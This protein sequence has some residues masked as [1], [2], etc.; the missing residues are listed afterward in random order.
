MDDSLYFSTPPCA[1]HGLRSRIASALIALLALVSAQQAAAQTYTFATLHTFAVSDGTNPIDGVFQ[2]SDGTLFG[3]TYGT[4]NTSSPSNDGGS[5]YSM[6]TDGTSFTVLHAFSVTNSGGAFN[7]NGA[8]PEYNPVLA[9]DGKLYGVT[10]QGGQGAYGVLYQLGTDGSG[11]TLYKQF[12][13]PTP[14]T[15]AEYQTNGLAIGSDGFLYGAGDSAGNADSSDGGAIDEWQIYKL[16]ITNTGYVDP[17]KQFHETDG[18][19]GFNTLLS[20]SDGNLYGVTDGDEDNSTPASAPVIFKLTT[21]GTYTQLHILPS[22][23]EPLA[24][25]IQGSGTALYGSTSEGGTSAWG[26]VFTINTDGTGFTTLHS[27]NGTTDGAY[28]LGRLLLASDGKLYG[29][30]Y[31]GGTSASGTAGN[32]YG[33]I[34][35]I[36][37]DGTGFTVIYNFTGATGAGGDHAYPNGALIQGSDG[38]FYGTTNDQDFNYDPA[39]GTGTIFSLA[40][41]SPSVTSPLTAS[42]SYGAPF[43]YTISG[44]NLPTSYSVTGTL[45]AGV[46]LTS[47]SGLISGTPTNNGS[48]SVTIGA[49]NGGGTGTAT[50]LITIAKATLTYH[51]NAASSVYGAATSSLGGTVTGFVNSDNQSTATTGTLSFTTT[52][53]P[54]SN[55]GTYAIDGTGLTANGGNYVFVQAAANSTAYTVGAAMLTYAANS[56]SSAHGASLAALGG[57]VTG[58]VNGDNQTSATTGTLSFSTT[59]TATSVVGNYAITGSGLTSDHGNYTFAQASGNSSAY[60]VTTATLTVSGITANGR[61]YNSS[62]AATINLTGAA[63]VGVM[64]GDT[65]TLGTGGATGSFL[66]KTVGTLKTVAISGLTLG[67]SNS[68]E[69]TLTQPM[70]MASISSAGLT[71]SGVTAS[72]K[73]YDSTQTAT[74]NT[75]SAALVGVFSGDTVTLGT[76]GATGL[77]ATKTVGTGK[78]VN[79]AGLTIGGADSGNYSLTQPTATASISS[80]SLNVSGATA[81]NKAYD[82]TLSATINTGGASLVGVFSGDTV[83][84][85]ASGATGTFATKTVGAG[86]TVTIAGLTLGGADSGNYSL[87]QPAA[88]ASISSAGLTVSGVTASGKV[89]DSTRTATIGTGSAA[90][91]GVFS[92]DTVTLGT[93]AATGL[94]ATKTVGVGKTVAIT[95]LTI[96]GADSGNY[97][98][99]QPTTTATISSADLTVSGVTASNK[100]Y[101]GSTL[102]TIGTSGAALVG[103]LGGDSVTLVTSGASGAFTDANAGANKTVTVAGLTI[104]G[105]DSGNYILTEPT[106][107]ATITAAAITPTLGSLGQTYDGTVKN[108]SIT[109]VP[110][111]LTALY[112]YNGVPQAVTLSGGTLSSYAAAIGQDIY[113]SVTGST[114]GTVYGTTTYGINSDVATAA[115]HD[116]VL[117]SGQQAV[118]EVSVLADQGSY[119]GSTQNGVSS[120]SEGAAGGS[121][122]IV[123]IATSGY[124]MGPVG[125]GTYSVVATIVDPNYTGSVSGTLVIG[126]ATPVVT[127]ATPLPIVYGVPLSGTQLDA[128]ANVAGTFAYTP[129]AGNLVPAGNP[130]LSVLFTPTDGTDYTTATGAVTLS[131]STA[132]AGVTLGSLSQTYS[133]A[134]EPATATTTPSSLT[135]NFTYNG[136]S[137]VPMT[138]GTYAVV[139]TISDPD[140]TGTAS[141][142]LV[143]GQATPVI[144]WPQPANVPAGTALSGTQLN[145]TANVPGVFT[146]NPPSGA[147]VASGGVTLGVLFTPSDTLDYTTATASVLL[148]TQALSQ[149]LSYVQPIN[150][151]TNA[152]PLTLQAMASSGLPVTFTVL[153]GPAM[154]NGST[155][156]VTG[157]PGLVT[158]QV[159][160]PGSDFYNP[161][162]SQTFTLSVQAVGPRMFFASTGGS[163]SSSTARGGQT[164]TAGPDTNVAAYVAPDDST[165]T[166]VAY[167]PSLSEGMVVTFT[168]DQN[169]NFSATTTALTG[170]STPGPTLTLTGQLA[171]NTLSGTISQLGISFTASLDPYDG[172][173]A[174]ISGYYPSPLINSSTGTVYSV[175]GTQ[176][177]VYVLTVGPGYV[178]GSL[179]TVGANDSYTAQTSTTTS[180]T[181]TIDPSTTTVTG[182]EILPSGATAQFGG[183]SGSTLRTDRLINLSSR[184]MV[185]GGQNILI[186]GFVIAGP[187]PKAVLLRAVGPG[188]D[189]FGVPGTLSTPKLTLEDSGG[190]LIASNSAWGGGASLASVF[191]RVGAFA[192]PAASADCA[193]LTTL[194]P[195]AYTM[196]V[197]SADAGAGG[198]ALAEIYDASVNPQSEYQRLVNISTRG[199]VTSGAGVLIGGFIVTGNSPKTLLI[200]GVGPGLSPFGVSGALSDPVLTVFDSA[201]NVLAQNDDWGTPVT[202]IPAQTAASPANIAAAEA[203]AG[204]FPFASGSKD[205][206]VIVTLQPGSYTAQV[207]GVGGATGTALIEVYEVTQ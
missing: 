203:L 125:A 198:I 178:Y 45:P 10:E 33:T 127:W 135:V 181:G 113:V 147:A 116:G 204:A 179:G 3:S 96:G 182:T 1:L 153:S 97:S 115:V 100:V 114:A 8:N 26:S 86:K 57:T 200:R 151:L 163:T 85:V 13:Y 199:Q 84:L 128:T 149:T 69:Y 167:F 32:G 55:T 129:A 190:N 39:I 28:P 111:G 80:A 162:P 176:D 5:V 160:Q 74:I 131:V 102:A 159:S 72:G 164:R 65:V 64:P 11:F 41:T 126:Q 58:F 15:L 18:G 98:L 40:G 150:L 194:A 88:T 137:T 109:T 107:T 144:T 184:G 120:L 7:T 92:G 185:S 117:T 168:P 68:S 49:I 189:N 174:G 143:I 37:T 79:I 43:S 54:S 29:T 42:G 17:F 119:T 20:A 158:I 31:Q 93:G 161:A 36:N 165:G 136:S 138:A 35:R 63:L 94:F 91:V 123:G 77:F 188:L 122:E 23:C 206:A 118:I 110:P 180:V 67:G 14:G 145:A 56:A 101:D 62:T 169:G 46:T 148:N 53:T 75:G 193:I 171:G 139:G 38:K 44:S 103:V 21:G 83:T 73:V 133:G 106:A 154:I 187:A 48:F 70:A 22:G 81:S 47:S 196:Q 195:G 76:S 66:T 207:A 202:V 175:V 172:P 155:L 95:G 27:F 2:T 146:Y 132:P 12:G 99:T 197:S 16:S 90:L 34:F 78:T 105:G 71:V 134:G 24:A 4:A 183:L 130:A 142:T 9:S 6:K 121:F 61:P 186:A 170:G 192:L 201:G 112:T 25:L 205:S 89:Y 60:T 166:L 51:A 87:T 191:A 50:L 19:V 141:G 152:A 59:A 156:T 30:C 124:T 108:A 104:S 52:A 140:Y 157:A 173:S 82:S 177:E